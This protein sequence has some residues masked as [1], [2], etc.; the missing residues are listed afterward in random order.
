MPYTSNVQSQTITLSR[1]IRG[2][3]TTPTLTGEAT[4]DSFHV[5][6]SQSCFSCKLE[7]S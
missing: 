5:Q 2:T 6:I 1:P 4:L 7:D 3:E